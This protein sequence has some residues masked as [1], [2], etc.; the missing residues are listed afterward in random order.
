[1]NPL[2]I[3]LFLLAL[4]F[5]SVVVLV[6]GLIFRGQDEWCSKRVCMVVWDDIYVL[7]GF[8]GV[9][10]VVSWSI[11]IVDLGLWLVIGLAISGTGGRYFQFDFGLRCIYL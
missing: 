9:Q 5:G 6:R 7:L 8:E 10:S 2:V 11:E 1:M 4:E 3:F